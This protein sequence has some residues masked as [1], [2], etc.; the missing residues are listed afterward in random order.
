MTALRWLAA[1]ESGL[2]AAYGDT[3]PEYSLD[4]LK[5]INPEFRNA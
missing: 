5:E 1:A 4:M 2:Q 3:E